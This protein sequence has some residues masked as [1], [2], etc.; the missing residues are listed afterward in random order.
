MARS[1]RKTTSTTKLEPTIAL[2]NVVFL[3]LVFFLIAGSVAPPLD[4]QIDLVDTTTLDG[5]PPPDAGVLQADGILEFRGAPV[6]AAEL[7]ARDPQPR[8][9]P[10][11]NVPAETLLRT[12]RELQAAGAMQIWIVTERGLE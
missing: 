2:I 11:R 7:V 9:V 1:L 5:R 3:M 8:L 4:D 6:T 10:D 12:A